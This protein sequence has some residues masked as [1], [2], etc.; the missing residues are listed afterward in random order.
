M[1]HLFVTGVI[2]TMAD[3]DITV[4]AVGTINNT[5]AACVPGPGSN[6][7]LYTNFSA[8]SPTRLR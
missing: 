3:E 1:R 6:A 7:G 8:A 5:T 4:C 2:A